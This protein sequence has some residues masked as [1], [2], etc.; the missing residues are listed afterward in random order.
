[1]TS[2]VWPALTALLALGLAATGRRVWEL[3][4]RVAELE[5]REHGE[6][7]PPPAVS[8]AAVAEEPVGTVMVPEQPETS[9]D[10]SEW[11]QGVP[12]MDS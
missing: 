2:R 8:P 7:A 9:A 4:T 3:R 12:P 6:I 1:M 11:E 10:F 5:A